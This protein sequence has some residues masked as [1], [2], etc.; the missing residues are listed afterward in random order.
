MQRR[1]AAVE[2]CRVEFLMLFVYTRAECDGTSNALF[3]LEGSRSGSNTIPFGD[4][5]FRSGNSTGLEM[6]P[7]H[8]Y[9]LAGCA[10]IPHDS[11]W[12][13]A[14]PVSAPRQSD[15]KHCNG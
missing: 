13:G 8:P 10:I 9:S 11:Y 1:Y 3:M 4:D 14:S 2:A 6:P 15:A 5:R 12:T 7:R